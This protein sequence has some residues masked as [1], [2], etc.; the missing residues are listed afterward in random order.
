MDKIV[1]VLNS[2]F[3]VEALLGEEA[4]DYASELMPKM[5]DVMM[6]LLP[7]DKKDRDGAKFL[8]GQMFWTG[9]LM[10]ITI[11]KALEAN[12]GVHAKVTSIMIAMAMEM[13][14]RQMIDTIKEDIGIADLKNMPPEFEELFKTA[15]TQ[16]PN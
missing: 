8:I 14:C 4:R 5:L 10:P 6:E 16:K 12:T 7:K 2:D 15:S 9:A 3:L 13:Q 1:K 11:S